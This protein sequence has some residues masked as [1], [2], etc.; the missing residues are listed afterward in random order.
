MKMTAVNILDEIEETFD[1]LDDWEDRYQYII[2]L[3]RR[4]PPIGV[5]FQTP[6]NEVHGCMSTVWLVAQSSGGSQ[7]TIELVADS[8]ALIVKGLLAIV[9]AA[10]S[11]LSPQAILE[12]DVD[13]LFQRLGLKRHLSPSRRNGLYSMV[14]RIRS[15][16]V[17]Y[18]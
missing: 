7:P 4:M 10:Y 18:A 12:F 6:E 3:G 13:D 8:D 14:K 2:D 16:A 9:L 15:H 11:G 17:D 5:E 1:L